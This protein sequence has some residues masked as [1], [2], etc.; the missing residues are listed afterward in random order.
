MCN[1]CSTPCI[2]SAEEIKKDQDKLIY[3]KSQG[4]LIIITG[5]EWAKIVGSL[6]SVSSNLVSPFLW[7]K[8]ITE[9]MI[10]DAIKNDQFYGFLVVDIKSTLELKQKYKQWPPIFVKKDVSAEMLPNWM[11]AEGRKN[12]PL[13]AFEAEGIFLHSLLV[14]WYLAQGFIITK[15]HECIEY[16][17]APVFKPFLQQ[18]YESRVN[19]VENNNK[20]LEKVVKLCSNSSYGRL[21][22][23]PSRFSTYALSNNKQ[24]KKQL[25]KPTYLDAESMSENLHLVKM[26]KSQY[27]EKYLLQ[28]GNAILMLSK[29][30][31][32]KFVTFIIDHMEAGTYRFCYT[33]TG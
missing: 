16:E 26:E 32:L 23:N 28:T 17:A 12:V 3:L 2:K 6:R 33:D 29:L 25:K 27:T 18:V 14:Q 15:I 11:D 4:T 8:W 22:L 20:I 9:E 10:I 21:I 13:Q 1:K 7:Q 5:C 24:L 19:A 30:N 31:V